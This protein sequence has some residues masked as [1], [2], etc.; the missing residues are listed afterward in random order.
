MILGKEGE[1]RTSW[2]RL[3]AKRR[4]SGEGIKRRVRKVFDGSGE[5]AGSFEAALRG[6]GDKFSIAVA[7]GA[8]SIVP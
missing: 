8:E 3:A 5:D 6:F 2:L 1:K 7:T 4:R